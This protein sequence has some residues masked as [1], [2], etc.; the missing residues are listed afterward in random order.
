M[1]T[2]SIAELNE[3]RRRSGKLGGRPRNPTATESR[4]QAL[5]RLLPRSLAVL[6]AHLESA[7][8]DAWRAALRI[9]E[10]AYGRPREDVGVSPLDGDQDLRLMSDEALAILRRQL[11]AQVVG[12]LTALPAAGE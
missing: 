2:V 4:Q 5:D 6:E 3:A 11:H 9:F 8:P 7:G 1:P 10:H 12:N